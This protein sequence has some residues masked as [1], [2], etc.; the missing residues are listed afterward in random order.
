VGPRTGQDVLEKINFLVLGGIRIADSPAHSPATM[1][2]V[3]WVQVRTH[4]FSLVG[5]GGMANLE[6]IYNLCFILKIIL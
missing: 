6:A 1:S 3:L 5:G 4:N 2:C